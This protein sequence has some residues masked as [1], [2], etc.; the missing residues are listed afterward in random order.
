MADNGAAQFE[1]TNGDPMT[2][3][4]IRAV[5]ALAR[6]AK[7]WPSTLKLVSM[8]GV[9]YVIHADDPRYHDLDSAARGE[10]VLYTFSGIPNDGGDW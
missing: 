8:G 6:L 2:L 3:E 9:L 1:G 4:E 5:R 10:S 7:R